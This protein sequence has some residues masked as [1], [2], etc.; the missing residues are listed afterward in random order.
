MSV[1]PIMLL[2]RTSTVGFIGLG[3]MGNHMLNNLVS[4]SQ[5]KSFAIF[6]VNENAMNNE[7]QRHKTAH[8]L[9]QILKCSS[10][11]EVATRASYVISMVP[12]S[13]H[14]QEVYTGKNSVLT[15]LKQ[16]DEQARSQTLCLDESTIEQSV[17][18]AVALK[19]R[20]VGADMMDAPVSGGK[21][22]LY[23]RRGHG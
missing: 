5:F 9:T 18:K 4:R 10:P 21:C 23:H 6:D 13:T 22:L 17:S 7:I 15:A 19:I 20:E 8:P 3:A 14:V 2:E 16:L 12:T 1:A 11:A